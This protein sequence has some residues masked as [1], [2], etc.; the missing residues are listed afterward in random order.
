MSRFFDKPNLSNDW[1]CPI[2]RTNKESPVILV[3]VPGTQDGNLC[4][5]QQIHAEC[6]NIVAK[7]YFLALDD[8]HNGNE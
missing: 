4:E 1:K 8:K 6:A 2:C 5:A 3:A 7:A